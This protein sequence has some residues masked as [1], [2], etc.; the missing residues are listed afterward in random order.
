MKKRHIPL[1]LALI[2][3]LC[4]TGCKTEGVHTHE[5]SGDFWKAYAENGKTVRVEL[6]ANPTTGF[7]WV[8]GELPSNLELKDNDY[9]SSD[10]SNT[11]VGAGGT[12]TLTF[13]VLAEGQ[14]TVEL[15][16]KRTW[17]GGETSYVLSLSVTTVLNSSGK[18]EVSD[19]SIQR[20]RETKRRGCIRS[21]SITFNRLNQKKLLLL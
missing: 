12:T 4:V 6:E 16:Y 21:P 19:I 8:V 11:R 20:V 9:E 1:L 3:I 5:T 13:K 14:G 15:T 2:A 10:K 17:E 7:Q 18:L